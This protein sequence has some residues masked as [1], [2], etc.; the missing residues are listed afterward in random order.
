MTQNEYRS[1]S[2]NSKYMKQTLTEVKWE[3]DKHI[4]IVED[5]NIHLS[6][7]DKNNRKWEYRNGKNEAN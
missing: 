6:A 7:T 3:T 1:N 5:F 2:L 4:I